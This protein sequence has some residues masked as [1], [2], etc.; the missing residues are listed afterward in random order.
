MTPHFGLGPVFR[1][2]WLMTSRRWQ[3]YALRSLFVASIFVALCVVW[4]AQESRQQVPLTRAALANTGEYFFYAVM[5]TQLTL[6]LLAAPAATAGAICL[7]KARGALL[8]LLVTDLSNS[9]I[10]LGK[11]AARLMPVLGTVLAALPVLYVSILLGG[12]DPEA[13]LGGFLVTLGVA[14]LACALALALSIWG[15][16]TY[17][18]LLAAYL[19]WALALLARPVWS[20]LS[21]FALVAGPPTWLDFSNPFWLAFAPYARPGTIGL[22]D[23]L[24]FLVGTLGLSA[25]LTAV[26]ILRVRAVTV[27]QAGHAERSR[28]K[29]ILGSPARNRRRQLLAPSLDR[30]PILWREWHWRRPSR[31]TRFIW[32]TYVILTAGFSLLAMG[33]TLG[34]N[35]GREIPA[36]VNAFQVSIGLL[37]LSVSSVTALAEER[38]RGSLEVLLA[39]PL[40]THAILWG[41]WWGAYRIVPRLAILPAAVAAALATRNGLWE[42]AVLISGLVLAY[43]AAVTSLGL[44]LAT[45]ERRAGRAIAWSVTLYA[46][47]TVGW[48]GAVLAV[49][50]AFSG[51][52][53]AALAS[54]SPFYGPGFLTAE[55]EQPGIRGTQL[56]CADFMWFWIGAYFVV[57]I[58]LFAATLITFDR[59]L[60]R[61]CNQRARTSPA[62]LPR[63]FPEP[64]VARE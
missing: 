62:G 29:V 27:R 32:G 45:W 42:G 36:F 31:W 12:I 19:L 30:N 41:K 26:A 13:V 11:L 6:V 34:L 21:G 22:A 4:L 60:G 49:A 20:A 54:A 59:C 3:M 47:V 25:I 16:K 24:A 40:P 46:L 64:V 37:L 56:R 15:T 10:V 39:T 18:V 38:A 57:A 2:E 23:D 61:V 63:L 48:F 52:L 28:R 33:L 43:G 17:E 5:G 1:F 51:E 8:H 50:R 9:E 55:M 58:L 7:D 14:V 35:S 44:A 53:G